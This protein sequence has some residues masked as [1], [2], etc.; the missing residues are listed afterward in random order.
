MLRSR[1]LPLPLLRHRREG[2]LGHTYQNHPA[3]RTPLRLLLMP[4]RV[5]LR[6]RGG[7]LGMYRGSTTA[8]GAAAGARNPKEQE[9][10]TAASDGQLPP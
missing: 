9:A 1:R 2:G 4:V 6:R 7:T 10:K 3:A 5:P 8:A